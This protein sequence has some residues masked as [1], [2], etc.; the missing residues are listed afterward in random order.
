MDFE[1]LPTRI[2]FMCSFGKESFAGHEH[3]Y[4]IDYNIIE[5]HDF[6]L[7]RRY[8]PTFSILIVNEFWVRMSTNSVYNRFVRS[9]KVCV[10]NCWAFHQEPIFK[11][12]LTRKV[13]PGNIP[14]K[15]RYV[16]RG[17][18]EIHG[19][20]CG[21]PKNRFV[22]NIRERHE[23]NAAME[24]LVMVIQSKNRSVDTMPVDDDVLWP[25]I[26]LISIDNTFFFPFI[27]Y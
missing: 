23:G 9:L 18:F 17:R 14:N 24:H 12:E 1:P 6:K 7:I 25:K 13:C 2:F 21:K 3:D 11:L 27:T 22:E 20:I 16:N 15:L 10:Q 8:N 19:H 4:L 26:K 5:W